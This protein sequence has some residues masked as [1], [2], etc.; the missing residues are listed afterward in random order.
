MAFSIFHSTE[1]RAVRQT[2]IALW[3]MVWSQ[4]IAGTFEEHSGR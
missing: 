3:Q 2:G 4:R 1:K